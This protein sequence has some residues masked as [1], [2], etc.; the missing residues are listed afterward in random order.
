MAREKRYVFSARTTEEGLKAL[1]EVKARLQVGWDEL[2]H[3]GSQ[4]SLQCRQGGD[5]HA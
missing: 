1:N 3:R 4:R 5:D 2:G